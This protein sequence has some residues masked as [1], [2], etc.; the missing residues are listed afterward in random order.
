ML[1]MLHVEPFCYYHL[2]LQFLSS[3][4][5]AART[6]MPQPPPHMHVDVAPLDSLPEEVDDPDSEE[7]DDEEAEEQDLRTGKRRQGL[8]ATLLREHVD[9]R[10]QI[11]LIQQEQTHLGLFTSNT[12]NAGGHVKGA[13]RRGNRTL[14]W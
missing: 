2:T 10:P 12:G 1:A 14:Q 7:E 9:P 4:Y 8:R 11:P 6:G 13:P 5:T 3:K